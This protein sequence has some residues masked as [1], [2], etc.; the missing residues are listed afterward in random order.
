MTKAR[1]R[2]APR[3]SADFSALDDFLKEQGKLEEFQAIAIKEVLA[4][5][6]AKAIRPAKA[7]VN[8]SSFSAAPPARR[9]W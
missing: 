7:R 5:Q 3:S 9:R 8:A 1:K 2:K 6:A 4:W